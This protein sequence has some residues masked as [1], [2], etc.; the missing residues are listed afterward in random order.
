MRTPRHLPLLALALLILQP[1]AALPQETKAPACSTACPKDQRKQDGCCPAPCPDG[2]LRLTPD[3]PACCWP[4]QEF[5]APQQLCLGVPRC[6]EGTTLKRGTCHPARSSE[7]KRRDI[8]RLLTLTGAARLGMASV[9][10]LVE[11]YKTAMPHVPAQF[12]TELRAQLSEQAL[13]ELL[14]PVYD[15]HLSH[16]DIKAMITFYQSPAGQRLTQALP[17]IQRDSLIAGQRWGVH[18]AAQIDERL[19][20]EG[21]ITP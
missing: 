11:S 6:P 2:M 15:K 13:I 4:G 10:Q 1:R 18:I 21:F 14:V 17:D 19:K 7:L 8:R 5:S 9:D 3:Q 16:D 12:W 20:Q